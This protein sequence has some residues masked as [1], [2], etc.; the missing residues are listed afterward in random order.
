MYRGVLLAQSTE[1]EENSAL[2]YT[3]YVARW[4][5]IVTN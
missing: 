5:R 2:S 4:K 3:K 1:I